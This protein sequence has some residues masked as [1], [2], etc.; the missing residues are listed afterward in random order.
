MDHETLEQFR[1]SLLGRRM[2]LLER[3][4]R[5]LAGEHELLAEREADWEDAAAAVTAVSVLESLGESERGGLARIQNAL[6]RID[7]GTYDECAVCHG[8]IDEER[9]RA[10]PDADRCGGCAAAH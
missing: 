10:V 2:S 6:E 9:L 7:R 3:R 4:Q 8:P 1:R 5:A